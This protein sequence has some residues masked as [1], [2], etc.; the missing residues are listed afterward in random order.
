M[1]TNGYALFI[2]FVCYMAA[3][4]LLANSTPYAALFFC[5]IALVATFF[6]A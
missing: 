5:V 1:K 3:I 4:V 2:A 6:V